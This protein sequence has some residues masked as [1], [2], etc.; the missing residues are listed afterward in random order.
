MEHVAARHR[1]LRY[2]RLRS[3]T[4]EG[5]RRRELSRTRTWLEVPVSM[6]V[7]PFKANC[8]ADS[9]PAL[10]QEDSDIAGGVD[11]TSPDFSAARYGQEQTRRFSRPATIGFENTRGHAPVVRQPKQT[12]QCGKLSVNLR[13]SKKASDTGRSFFVRS[14]VYLSNECL[15]DPIERNRR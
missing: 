6:H 14:C 9:Q 13:P 2:K 3:T 11:L 4:G 12:S 8:L 10:Q 1:S 15:T 7:L 5:C